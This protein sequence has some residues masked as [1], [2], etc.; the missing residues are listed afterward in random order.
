MQSTLDL[1][2]NGSDFHNYIKPLLPSQPTTKKEYEYAPYNMSV[3][4]FTLANPKPVFKVDLTEVLDR[5]GGDVPILVK[6][7]IDAI[8]SEAFKG[9]STDGV[10]RISGI[11][12][13]VQKLKNAFDKG[14]DRN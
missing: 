10:Y 6:K 9:L 5:D 12:T 13:D 11:S 7:C 3:A 1:I 8:E 4:A 14:T 2:N